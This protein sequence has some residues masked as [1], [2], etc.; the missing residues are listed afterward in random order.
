MSSESPTVNQLLSS[1]W[2]KVLSWQL[3]SYIGK[4][5]PDGEPV[6]GAEA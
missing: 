1:S 2:W 3:A 6:A 5:L 4:L